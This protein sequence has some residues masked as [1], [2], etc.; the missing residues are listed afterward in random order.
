MDTKNKGMGPVLA[1]IA[2]AVVLWGIGWAVFFVTGSGASEE[3]SPSSSAGSASTADSNAASA[4]QPA[5]SQADAQQPVLVLMRENVYDASG[6]LSRQGIYSYDANGIK[7]RVDWSNSAYTEYDPYGNVNTSSYYDANG[8]LQQEVYQHTY[9]DAGNVLQAWCYVNNTLTRTDTYTYNAD[10]Q[11]DTKKAAYPDGSSWTVQYSY[12]DAGNLVRESYDNG[13]P[14]VVYTYDAAGNLLTDGT[15][16][17]E[18]DD[19]GNMV[20]KT[21]QSDGYYYTYLYDGNG[22]VM[23]M[24]SFT[25]MGTPD[26][27]ITYEYGAQ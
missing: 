9:D 17:Y 27:Y 23:Q 24:S 7:T 22:N 10:G 2:A 13:K 16:V 11:W 25:A 8:A 19:S 15:Y 1:L 12:D 5:D 6:M 20:K 3:E 14:D 4:S 18:Y 26:G 21:R